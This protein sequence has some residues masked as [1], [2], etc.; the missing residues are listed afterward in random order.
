MTYPDMI[1][2]VGYLLK[3]KPSTM[4]LRKSFFF[5]FFFW[6]QASIWACGQGFMSN[7]LEAF[8]GH[9]SWAYLNAPCAEASPCWW[10]AG[11]YMLG[12]GDVV[13]PLMSQPHLMLLCPVS[14]GGPAL[15][16]SLSCMWKDQTPCPIC[17]PIPLS[18]ISSSLPFIPNLVNSYL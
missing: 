14:P 18:G 10:G 9:L 3:T 11:G 15:A 6:P 12:P 4:H 1:Y 2:H 8:G 7:C 5:F 13:W 16:S 17:T